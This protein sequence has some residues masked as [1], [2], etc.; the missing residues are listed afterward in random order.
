[1]GDDDVGYFRGIVEDF[2]G[3]GGWIVVVYI[4]FLCVFGFIS[5][6]ELF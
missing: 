6:R 5:R 3:F 1:M 4:L 2:I